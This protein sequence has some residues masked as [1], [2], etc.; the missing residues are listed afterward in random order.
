M[1]PN[2]NIVCSPSGNMFPRNTEVAITCLSDNAEIYYTTD[3]T[4][5]S[6]ENG[7]K[8]TEPIV[9][10]RD[11]V[12]KA[13][14]YSDEISISDVHTEMY[15]V[16]TPLEDVPFADPVLEALVM[17][18]EK[19]YAEDILAIEEWSAGVSDL[20]GIEYLTNLISLRLNDD[21]ITDISPVSQLILLN[22]LELARNNITDITPLSSLSALKIVD[23]SGNSITELSPLFE[24]SNIEELRLS[25]PNITD[26]S[27]LSSF[28]NLIRLDLSGTSISDFSPIGAIT[29][30]EAVWMHDC[31]I[32]DVSFFSSMNVLH[33][34]AIQFNS[35]VDVSPLASCTNL[36]HLFLSDNSI[37]TG[38]TSLSTLTKL[39]ELDLTNNPGI[40]G[41]DITTLQAALPDC[42]IS[43]P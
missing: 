17:E 14:S 33:N 20:S 36:D 15:M 39:E 7:I 11:I 21:M 32:V 42:T 40:P 18:Q 22:N 27:F 30:L 34:L 43:G 37:T 13:V 2:D 6:A 1:P 28:P 24:L 9:L 10:T 12:L 41:G 8:Y 29:Q 19:E 3:G 23:V 26:V 25:G 31:G 38:V 5:P 4:E 35:I 16:R